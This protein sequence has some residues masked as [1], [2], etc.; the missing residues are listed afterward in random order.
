MT[1]ESQEAAGP[2]PDIPQ[3][4]ASLPPKQAAVNIG[5]RTLQHSDTHGLISTAVSS[6]E[7]IGT[8]EPNIRSQTAASTSKDTS[9]S[10]LTSAGR[11]R[12]G[13]ITAAELPSIRE[14]ALLLARFACNNHSICDDELRPIGV[15]LYPRGSMV[16]HDCQP[17][18]MQSFSSY[19]RIS[20]RYRRTMHC[21]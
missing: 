12:E 3:P 13:F 1:G 10:T 5:N 18:C 4:E 20:F 7:T 16:N 11:L 15:G 2:D 14:M 8:G 9:T 6:S 21:D 19:G 17:N